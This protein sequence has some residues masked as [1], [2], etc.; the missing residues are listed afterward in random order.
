MYTKEQVN[1][2]S[3]TPPTES[4]PIDSTSKCN[5]QLFDPPTECLKLPQP[6][7]KLQC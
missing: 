2:I 1:N 6:T 7:T 5:L 4:I 3:D